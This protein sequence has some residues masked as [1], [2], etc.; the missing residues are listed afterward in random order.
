MRYCERV[1]SRR[2]D[3]SPSTTKFIVENMAGAAAAAHTAI[4]KGQ[5]RC[6]GY[7]N[8]QV[9]HNPPISVVWSGC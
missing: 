4:S 8:R 5:L 3:P 1:E 9:Q 6:E 2:L 7:Y